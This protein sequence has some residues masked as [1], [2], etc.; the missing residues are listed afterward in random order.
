MRTARIWPY[1]AV[2]SPGTFHI[3][4]SVA[5]HFHVGSSAS[6]ANRAGDAVRPEEI[7]VAA[8][9]GL[10]DVTGEEPAVA[11][12]VVRPGRAV[13]GEAALDLPIVDQE[14]EAAAGYV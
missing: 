5:A 3:V 7:E 9:I 13:R 14:V 6:R 12:G 1:R 8:L 10:Q 11:A 4:L 2:S